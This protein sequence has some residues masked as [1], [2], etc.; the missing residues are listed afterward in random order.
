MW[1][2]MAGSLYNEFDFQVLA[3]YFPGR[4]EGII[5]GLFIYD[6]YSPEYIA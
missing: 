2:R 5:C 3:H 1:R 4:A 6:V